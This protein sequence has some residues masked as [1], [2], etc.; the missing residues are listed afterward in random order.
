MYAADK[1]YF[2]LRLRELGFIEDFARMVVTIPVEKREA[3]IAW[4]REL[5]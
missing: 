1:F 5:K 2:G 4:L 3:V